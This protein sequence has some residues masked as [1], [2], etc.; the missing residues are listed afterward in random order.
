[1]KTR[2]LF[3]MLQDECIALFPDIPGT[4]NPYSCLNYMHIGQHGIGPCSIDGTRKV[5]LEEYSALKQELENLGYRFKFCH[6]I[7]QNSLEIRKSVL[8]GGL[9]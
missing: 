7:P 2:V 5:K 4:N 3:R 6:R 8:K 9:K 1:M